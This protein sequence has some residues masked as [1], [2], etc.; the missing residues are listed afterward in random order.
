M[1]SAKKIACFI[2]IALLAAIGVAGCYVP[3]P[4]TPGGPEVGRLWL[5]IYTDDTV[6]ITMVI[7]AVDGKDGHP[8]TDDDT[9]AFYADYITSAETEPQDLPNECESQRPYH[10]VILKAAKGSSIISSIRVTGPRK[11][12]LITC[13]FY[14]N[15]VALPETRVDRRNE[16]VCRAAVPAV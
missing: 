1:R 5:C 12:T 15:G 11:T 4:G 10:Q 13:V 16:V 7:N 6:D 3:P 9:G 2:V 8:L 14:L